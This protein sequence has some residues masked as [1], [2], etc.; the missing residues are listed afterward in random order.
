MSSKFSFYLVFAACDPCQSTE[1]SR[2]LSWFNFRVARLRQEKGLAGTKSWKT[3][4]QTFWSE[5]AEASR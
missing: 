5:K 1:F 2:I 4:D 3:T